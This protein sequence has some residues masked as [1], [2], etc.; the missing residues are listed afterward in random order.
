MTSPLKKTV[1][2]PGKG[3]DSIFC[4]IYVVLLVYFTPHSST[5]NASPYQ[6]T[7][8]ETQ[9]G[10]SSKE[11]RMLMKGALSHNNGEPLDLLG[12]GNPSTSTTQS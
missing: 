2:S 7:L 11:T 12:L 10:S 1:L 5:I 3:A 6:E 8:K 9:G 4:E